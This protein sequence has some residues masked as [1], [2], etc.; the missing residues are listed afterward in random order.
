ME[1]LRRFYTAITE[2]RRLWSLLL[3]VN[4]LGSLYGFY[5]YWPQLRVTPLW[6]WL[7]VPDSPGAT[8]LFT[9]LLWAMLRGR[10]PHW[11]AALACVSLMK[12]G[13]WTAIVLPHHAIWAG[14]W[15][16]EDIYLSLSHL[17]MWLQGLLFSLRYPVGRFWALI[18]LAFM[19]FQ[20]WIDYFVLSTHPTLPD[21][22]LLGWAALTA[23]AL[24]AIWGAYLVVRN[25]RVDK[26]V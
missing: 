7:I 1:F 24:S 22:R 6:Q 19:A 8:F 15:L 26:P 21:D 16:P 4:L 5:W 10:R 20:D 25:W 9:L 23:G 14:S 3:W 2:D 12:Y 11:L 18:A 17:G 13:M